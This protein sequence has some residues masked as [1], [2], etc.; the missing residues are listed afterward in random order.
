ML[1]TLP[2]EL[3]THILCRFENAGQLLRFAGACSI[4]HMLEGQLDAEIWRDLTLANWP[5]ASTGSTVDMFGWL[6]KA[7]YKFYL[8]RSDGRSSMTY[9]KN[10]NIAFESCSNISCLNNAYEFVIEFGDI[11]YA[12]ENS[13]NPNGTQSTMNRG[14]RNMVLCMTVSE[15]GEFFA[16]HLEDYFIELPQRIPAVELFV[17]RRL[18]GAIATLFAATQVS[19]DMLY[20]D[21][22]LDEFGID[23]TSMILRGRSKWRRNPRTGQLICAESG[24]FDMLGYVF[25]TVREDNTTFFEK[26]QLEIEPT[27]QPPLPRVTIIS[28]ADVARLLQNLVSWEMY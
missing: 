19:D 4:L 18:D 6:W 24:D 21:T 28:F 26:M 5:I 1:T 11:P 25:V 27:L 12:V 8:L 16:K 20:D 13:F 17:R 15:S 10:D 22:N 2:L 9:I 23:R 3:L 14:S 7:R